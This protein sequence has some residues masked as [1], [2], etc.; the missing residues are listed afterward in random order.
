[1]QKI[2]TFKRGAEEDIP[3]TSRA[4]LNNFPRPYL[5]KQEGRSTKNINLS[6]D[7]FLRDHPKAVNQT[8]TSVDIDDEDNVPFCND[9]EDE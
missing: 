3:K 4:Q 9:V 5:Y 8:Y 6:F 1:L 7:S 2:N